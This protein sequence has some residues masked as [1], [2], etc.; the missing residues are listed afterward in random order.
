MRKL[1][2]MGLFLLL[3]F[4]KGFSQPYVDVANFNCQHFASDY[5][6]SP[7]MNTTDVYGL[8]LLL[9]K[10]FKD[11]S[12]LLC[13]T[14]S[15]LIH[16]QREW[17][18]KTS[19]DLS[20]IAVALGYQWTS[21]SQ[22]W[23]TTVF[24][25]PK[26]ASDFERPLHGKDWQ[27]GGLFLEEYKWSDRLQI[28]FGLFANREAFGAFFVPLL[29]IDW[30]AT[31]RIYCYGV[32]PASY[33]FEYNAVKDKL[34]TGFQFRT[35]THS[36]HI[37]ANSDNEYVR[38]DEVVVKGF[39]DYAIWNHVILNAEIGYSL[40]KSPLQYDMDSD[41]Q[42]GT[43]PIYTPVKSFPVFSVGL[44]YRIRTN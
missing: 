21:K 33:K 23:K 8:N 24:A 35:Q 12:A 1:R 15:E 28:K 18:A 43:N 6:N 16:S 19:S 7:A 4:G 36:F 37:S 9:P 39:A 3:A 27:Y 13:R 5:K 25:I 41:H 30:K 38:F 42:S 40:G 17:N 14:S 34:Y 2:F 31:D 32:L 29:G 11:G 10:R 22:K 44:A 20:S 26:I